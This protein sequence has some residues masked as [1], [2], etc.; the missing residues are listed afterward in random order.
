MQ[1]NQCGWDFD[2]T[3]DAYCSGCGRC[4]RALKTDA[5]SLRLYMD[6][7][8]EISIPV[9]HDGDF[10]LDIVK[11]WQIDAPKGIDLSATLDGRE[12][13][14]V[15]FMPGDKKILRI[16]AYK[17]EALQ[18]V[19]KGRLSINWGIGP[20]LA[21]NIV[22]S[23]MPVFSISVNDVPMKHDRVAVVVADAVS[24]EFRFSIEAS[25]T[26]QVTWSNFLLASR[27]E[28]GRSVD[29]GKMPAL[30]ITIKN[31]VPF[32]FEI[33]PRISGLDFGEGGLEAQFEV[34]GLS[35]IKFYIDLIKGPK[36]VHSQDIY[37][38]DRY[39]VRGCDNKKRK[40]EILLE[41]QGAVDARIQRVRTISTPWLTLENQPEQKDLAAFGKSSSRFKVVVEPSKMMEIGQ[42]YW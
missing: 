5:V 41:N 37:L 14:P 32:E 34:D 15:R 9:H 13:P 23:P 8:G 3:S 36:I 1:C 22:C 21:V 11:I 29:V 18:L 33:H 24:P 40:V 27:K 10:A 19:E 16:R 35:A 26:D 38:I 31:N 6:R 30:P 42:A 12:V 20:P 2:E 4:L 28:N 17:K 25:E 39:A 7:Y